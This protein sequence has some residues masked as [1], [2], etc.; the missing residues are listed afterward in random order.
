MEAKSSMERSWVASLV[1]ILGNR[2]TFAGKIRTVSSE[3]I[4][5]PVLS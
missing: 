2:Q 3:D 5:A 1:V 4:V